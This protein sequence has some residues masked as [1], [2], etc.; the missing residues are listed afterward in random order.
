[1]KL[2]SPASLLGLLAPLLTA[3]PALAAAQSKAG[4]P[5]ASPGWGSVWTQP[6]TDQQRKRQEVMAKIKAAEQAHDYRTILSLSDQLA[7]LAPN[8]PTPLILHAFARAQL[9][10]FDQAL[11]DL[12]RG[13]QLAQKHDRNDWHIPL[14][15]VRS[16]VH[17]QMQDYA[18]TATDLQAVLLLDGHNAEALNDLAWLRATAPDAAVRNGAESVHLARKAVALSSGR[19]AH[20]VNDTLAAAYAEAGDYTRAIDSEKRSLTLADKEKKSDAESQKF[21]KEASVRLGLFEQHRA[22][23]ANPL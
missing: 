22:Y 1:M 9:K 17:K 7:A 2:F 16:A 18:A 13:E 11:G 23:H 3:V 5:D 14:L 19:N 6:A 20:K 8:T 21:Q 15:I 4:P 10:Q 12:D